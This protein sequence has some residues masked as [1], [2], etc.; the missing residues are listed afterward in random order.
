MEFRVEVSPEGHHRLLALSSAA[1]GDCLS[2]FTGRRVLE[3]A[4]HTVQVS[5]HEHIWLEPDFL[6]YINHSCEPNVIF[7]VKE[8]V[9]RALRPIAAGDEIMYFYPATEWDMAAPFECDCK[10]PSCLKWIQG[11]KHVPGDVLE[12]YELAPHIRKVLEIALAA[13][14]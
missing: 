13:R 11:A 4:R 7:D 2:L 8:M 1:T 9:L 6:Q 12:K 3:P 14:G 10:T 5:V